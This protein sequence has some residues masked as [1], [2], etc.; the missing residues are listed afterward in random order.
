MLIK[1]KNIKNKA[2]R[3]YIYRITSQGKIPTYVD[4]RGNKQYDTTDYKNYRATHKRGR[5]T[6]ERGNE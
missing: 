4:E 1:I 3:A 2:R 5:P 6:K